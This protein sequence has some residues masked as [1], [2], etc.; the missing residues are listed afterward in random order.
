VTEDATSQTDFSSVTEDVTSQT[1]FS[2]VTEDRLDNR[3]CSSDRGCSQSD[4]L[5]NRTY[6]RDRVHRPI[7]HSDRG[8]S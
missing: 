2:S 4:R 6:S 1:D 7:F 8:S 5:D 3:I